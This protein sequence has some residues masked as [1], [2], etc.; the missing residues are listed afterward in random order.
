MIK[1][2]SVWMAIK[3]KNEISQASFN[4][5]SSPFPDTIQLHHGKD[6]GKLL[7]TFGGLLLGYCPKPYRLK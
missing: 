5:I 6:S 1:A 7:G 4:V 3:G 2:K